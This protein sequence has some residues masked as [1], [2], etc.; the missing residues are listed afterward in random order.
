MFKVNNKDTRIRKVNDKFKN[1]DTFDVVLASS[2]L[3][4]NTF[5]FLFT[6]I[7]DFDQLI[8]DWGCCLLFRRFV[9]AGIN[10]GKAC[11]YGE[12]R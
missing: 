3:I 2:L 6:S 9:P 7:V 4:S 5:H 8:D 1:K 10:L 12:T 11:T